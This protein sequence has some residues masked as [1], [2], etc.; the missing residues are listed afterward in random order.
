MG[1]YFSYRQWRENSFPFPAF[2]LT[3]ELNNSTWFCAIYSILETSH[4]L[5]HFKHE[6]INLYS[7]KITSHSYLAS[8]SWKYMLRGKGWVHYGNGRTT[9]RERNFVLHC[10]TLYDTML[11]F[12]AYVIDMNFLRSW[13]VWLA[14]L[15]G[16]TA[17][18]P[19]HRYCAYHS[20]FRQK[21]W[22]KY[23]LCYTAFT[24]VVL[25]SIT[26]LLI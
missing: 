2:S 25:S 7:S 4:S 17:L 24:A 8:C 14:S 21:F 23:W 16:F 19:F 6:C 3:I 10:A 9:L 12:D 20:F 13:M 15:D 5:S 22:F 26:P 18:C 11:Y 1:R